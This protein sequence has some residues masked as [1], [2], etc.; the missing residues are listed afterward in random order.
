MSSTI[1]REAP[2]AVAMGTKE[3]RK[4]IHKDS[5]FADDYKN[6]PYKFSKP[7]KD[8]ARNICFTCVECGNEMFITED[9]LLVIC[10]ICNKVNRTKPPKKD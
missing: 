7:K 2:N 4:K 8:K 5:K 1:S 3:Y 6:L 10:S 9:T